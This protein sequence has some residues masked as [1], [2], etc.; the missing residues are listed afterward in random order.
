MKIVDALSSADKYS[1]KYRG[2]INSLSPLKFFFNKLK[3][4]MIKINLFYKGY[5]LYVPTRLLKKTTTVE[6]EN[7]KIKIPLLF[8]EYLEFVYGQDWIKPKKD[9]I[10][11]QDYKTF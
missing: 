5:S 7:L 2:V 9:Y 11:P 10:W 1:G 8:K 6:I 4:I 3:K